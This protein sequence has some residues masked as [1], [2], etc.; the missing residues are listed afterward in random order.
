M[1]ALLDKVS[2]ETAQDFSC[3]IDICRYFGERLEEEI[4]G[5][6][7]VLP[8]SQLAV[9]LWSDHREQ[10]PEL[11][12]TLHALFAERVRHD[13]ALVDLSNRFAALAVDERHH[14][15]ISPVEPIE[16]MVRKTLIES[17]LRAEADAQGPTDH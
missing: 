6:E 4:S 16:A 9:R 13:A 1:A 2:R 3:S 8:L 12:A 5:R 15:D 14:A 7:P 11:V 17:A 10:V